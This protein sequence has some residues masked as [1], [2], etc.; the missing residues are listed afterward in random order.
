MQKKIFLAL[1]SFL[2][3]TAKALSNPKRH[4][5]EIGQSGPALSSELEI[6]NPD[7]KSTY[8]SA[9]H[10]SSNF[11]FNYAYLFSL[12]WQIGLFYKSDQSSYTYHHKTNGNTRSVEH[13]INYG[14]SFAYNFSTFINSSLYAGVSISHFNHEEEISHDFLENE[15]KAPFEFDDSGEEYG[16]FLGKRFQFYSSK[17]INLSYSP[18]I[19]FFHRFHHKDLRDQYISR[20]QGLIVRLINFNMLF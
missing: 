17:L 2:S 18:N 20:S 14:L 8:K 19:H 10:L 3:I 6:F 9:H 15:G 4:V 1:I 16:I 13:S 5:I 11:S 12:K 7:K